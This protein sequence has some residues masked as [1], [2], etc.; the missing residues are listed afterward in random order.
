MTLTEQENKQ[1]EIGLAAQKL[2]DDPFFGFLMNE[3][4]NAYMNNIVVS[5]PEQQADR[6]FSYHAIKALQD[7][8]GTLAQWVQVKENIMAHIEADANESE[9]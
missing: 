9:D 4:A 5:K 1:V 6:E 2:L 3:M 7:I 8:N